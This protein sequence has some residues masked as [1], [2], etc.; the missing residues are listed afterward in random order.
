MRVILILFFSFF[1][2]SYANNCL[3]CH[4]GIEPIRELDSEMMKEILEISKKVG[5]PGN[6]CIVC[7]GGNPEAEDKENAHKGTVEVFLQGVKTEHGIKKGPQNFYPDPGSPW[8]N[9]YTCGI[10]HQEQVRTQFTSLMFTE[11]GKIQGSLWGFGGINGYQHDI[12]NY[13]VKT[14]DLHKTLGTKIYKEYMQK[15]KKLEPQVF[16]EK[17]KGLPAAPTAEEVEKNPQLAVYTYLR[18]E[19]LRCH[20]GVKGR[21]KRGDYRG[22][23]CS[24]CH[25]PYSNEGF[26]EGND[27]TI[28]KDER[29][30]MLVHTIQGTRDAK[31][32]INGI[33]YSGIPVETC[34]TCH[35][36]GKRIGTSFQGLMETAYFSP[37]LEDGSPQPKLHTKHYIHL[38]PDIHLKKGMV[39]QDCHTSIDVHSDGTLTGTTLAPVEI[40]CQDCHGTPD[41]YPWELPIGYSDEFGGNVPA[42]GKPRGVSF[43]IPEYMEK[44]EKYPPKDGYLLTARGNPFG[45][46]VRDGDEVIVHTAGGKDIRL[47]PLKKLKEKGKLKKE[48]QVAMV[49]IKNHINKMECYTCHST[50]APQCYGCHIKIDYSKPVKHPDWVSIGNDHDSSG[51]TAD[52][53]G[54]I[55][56]HLIEGNIVETRSYLRWEN[57]PLA[58]N[59]ENRISPAV[60]GCQTTVTVI[61]K[62]GKPLLLNHIFRIPNVEGAGEKGQLAIDIS[63][64]QP[65]TVQKESRSCE[66]CHTNP[67]AMGY[68]IERGKIY[69]NPS[70]PYVV[71]LTT[72]DGK[73]I[74]KKYKTQINSIKNLEYDWSRFVSEDGTQLQTVGHHFKN[75][76]PLNNKERAKLDRRGVCLSCHQTMPDRDIA[77][78][79]MVHVGEIADIDID[80]DMHRFILHKLIIMGAW[81]QVLIVAGISLFIIIFPLWKKLKRG[82]K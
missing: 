72:P 5:Y 63:P 6:D 17:M 47:K 15:L 59:G 58:V 4:K 1:L 20:T 12:G 13:A 2:V 79:L 23:G 34:T 67:V 60:P 77:V 55:K 3:K 31:V 10:C 52:A 43:S 14:V 80:N 48:A 66:S 28:P 8:I 78:S 70:K 16:P 33:E 46:V 68:G 82:K 42:K 29:G 64:I 49:Q 81:V 74:P 24:S 71:E 18:Q 61:G 54:E 40:E 57:P 62:D 30:H 36:R 38:K 9:Q 41:K 73:I 19:C 45:N 56:K 25:I 39:C 51:L 35:D 69:E 11:A 76:R 21:S 26:Y 37:F 22:L 7:H 75:S 50:W 44:G 27:P 53:R 32:K 65:H